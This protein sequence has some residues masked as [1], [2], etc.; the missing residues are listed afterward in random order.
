MLII[1]SQLKSGANNSVY[2][3][4]KSYIFYKVNIEESSSIVVY[5]YVL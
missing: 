4:K 1:F 3:E 2:F 5:I